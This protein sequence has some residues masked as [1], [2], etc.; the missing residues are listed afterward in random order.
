MRDLITARLGILPPEPDLVADLPV[1]GDFDLNPA[2]RAL[3]PEDRPLRRAAVLIPLVDRPEAMTVLLT[4]RT[5]HLANH[6]GQV[7][8]P[9]GR[10]EPHDRGPVDAA[11]RET[12]EEVGLARGFIDVVG[13]LDGYETGT[14]FHISPIVGLVRTGFTLTPDPHEV[15][16]VFEVPLSFI[17]DR[18]NHER[19]SGVWQ[20]LERHY[21]AIPF[22]D[23]FIWG[24]TAGMLVNLVERL[25]KA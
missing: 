24:A 1:R 23:R 19:R 2:L 9:G 5:D 16:D 17:L 20:G 4:R 22:G 14:G 7:A 8:F 13:A 3:A 6:A 10:V 25:E 18:R 11:L 15:A 12:E 21:W